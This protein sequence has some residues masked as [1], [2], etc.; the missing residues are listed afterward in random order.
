MTDT[1]DAVL[2]EVYALPKASQ[3][4][5]LGDRLAAAHAAE[6]EVLRGLLRECQ[7]YVSSMAQASHLTDG[8]S[9]KPANEHDRLAERID[10]AISATE[11]AHEA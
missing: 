5:A 7:P 1:F 6:V 2:A 9:P 10:A 3:C 4:K 11:A 8:F